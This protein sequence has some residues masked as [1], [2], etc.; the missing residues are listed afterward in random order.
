VP[1]SPGAILRRI[2]DHFQF[3]DETSVYATATCAIVD[4][5][6]GAMRIACAGH[7]LPIFWRPGAGASLLHCEATTPL[8]L[9]DLADVP[10]I[11]H[12]LAPGDRILFYTDGVTDREAPSGARY[13]IERL[14]EALARVAGLPVVNGLQSIVADIELFA[15]G[16]EPG[17]DN[18]LLLVG[19]E[20]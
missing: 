6:A 2:H 9:M 4:A 16:I 12:P 8:L 14:I 17:D 3:L 15:D 19:I 7:P 13:E 18:T 1:E 10:E 11:E 20:G 5:R